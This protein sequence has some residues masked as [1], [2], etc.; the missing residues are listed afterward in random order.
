MSYIVTNTKEKEETLVN[1]N[2]L[3]DYFYDNLESEDFIKWMNEV[4]GD[5]NL[6][7]VGNVPTGNLVHRLIETRSDYDEIFS[8]WIKSIVEDIP[9]FLNHIEI[10][11]CGDYEIKLNKLTN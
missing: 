4:F 9:E 2:E 3:Y 5:T 6:P 1:D 7:I 10:V 11:Y 8:D